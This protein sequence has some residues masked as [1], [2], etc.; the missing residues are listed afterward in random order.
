M[1]LCLQITHQW[2]WGSIAPRSIKVYTM[3][4][5]FVGVKRA[6]GSKRIKRILTSHGALHWIYC[7]VIY[8]ASIHSLGSR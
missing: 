1:L 7:R 6:G 2:M 3:H 5:R 4:V 8:R